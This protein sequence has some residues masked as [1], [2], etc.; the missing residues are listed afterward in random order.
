MLLNKTIV[1][2]IQMGFINYDIN[3]I[4]TCILIYRKHLRR[5]P[6]FKLKFNHIKKKEN[7]LSAT[8]TVFRFYSHKFW[9]QKTVFNSMTFLRSQK[10]FLPNK[11]IEEWDI[12]ACPDKPFPQPNVIIKPRLHQKR[13][14]ATGKIMFGAKKTEQEIYFTEFNVLTEPWTFQKLCI[15]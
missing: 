12:S 6:H 8:V 2:I 1:I 11:Q 10:V 9:I 4:F 7:F 3:C 14:N 13:S 15:L 5:N